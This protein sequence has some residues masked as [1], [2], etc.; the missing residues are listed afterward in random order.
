M[1]KLI[2]AIQAPEK[3]VEKEKEKLEPPLEELPLAP[4]APP[5]LPYEEF[6]SASITAPMTPIM[7]AVLEGGNRGDM[8]ASVTHLGYSAFPVTLQ[9]I[10]TNDRI[11]KD[12]FSLLMFH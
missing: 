11:L 5:I 10:P 4:S 1:C 2:K 7:Q 8:E 3:K 9:Q 12:K 6:S